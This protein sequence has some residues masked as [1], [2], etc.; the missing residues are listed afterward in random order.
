MRTSLHYGALALALFA[1]AGLAGAADDGA[2]GKINSGVATQAPTG[3]AAPKS[4]VVSP[5]DAQSQPTEG[6]AANA[7]TGTAPSGPI[8]A[9]PQTMPSTVSAEN[10]K[11]DKTPIMAHGFT[12]RD[13]DKGVIFDSIA[14]N[15]DVETRALDVK[16]ADALP[17][18]VKIFDLPEK[19]TEQMPALKGYKYVKLA[20]KIMIVSAPNRIVIAEITR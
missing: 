19:V 3:A 20:D 12:L 16:P 1:S 2:S 15:A 13:E 14:S 10:A 9:T 5:R 17:D 7:N 8:G 11:L 18:D 4:E 6:P